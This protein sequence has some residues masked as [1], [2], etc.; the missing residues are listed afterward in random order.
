MRSVGAPVHH[1]LRARAALALAGV[2]PGIVLGQ[3]S[4]RGAPPVLRTV[5]EI[6][7]T[8][9]AVRFD[10]QTL[11]TLSN[12]LYIAHMDADQLVVVD[13]VKRT[14]LATL[15][16]FDR[17]HGVIVAPDVGRVYASV[18]GRHDVAEVP[19]YTC[20]DPSARLAT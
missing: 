9:P 18:T 7:L 17:V 11:D 16:G 19:S 20:T 13:V 8:G 14:L 4:A 10:Y 1:P 2:V 3:T 15:N 12:R 6:P 5:A